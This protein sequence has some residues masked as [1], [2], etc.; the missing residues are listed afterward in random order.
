[1]LPLFSQVACSLTSA[2]KVDLR[3]R[4]PR[5][6]ALLLQ[7]ALLNQTNLGTKTTQCASHTVYIHPKILHLCKNRHG[8]PGLKRTTFSKASCFGNSCRCPGCFNIYFQKGPCFHWVPKETSKPNTFML[9]VGSLR[10][11]FR[12]RSQF[13]LCN[14]CVKPWFSYVGNVSGSKSM[15]RPFLHRP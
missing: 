6:C 8:H 2:P 7:R 12:T 11:K 1:M 5:K 4:I 13:R 3:V 14:H 10:L 9:T 15:H